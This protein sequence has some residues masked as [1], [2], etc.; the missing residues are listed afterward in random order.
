MLWITSLICWKEVEFGERLFLHC[1]GSPGWNHVCD[2]LIQTGLN[3]LRL[4]LIRV[5]I[6]SSPC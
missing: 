5:R 1:L 3:S 2:G 4:S 6:L